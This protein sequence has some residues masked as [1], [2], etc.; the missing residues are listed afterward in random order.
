MRMASVATDSERRMVIRTRSTRPAPNYWPLPQ[1]QIPRH[2]LETS[3]V[4]EL[5]PRAWRWISLRLW[6]PTGLTLPGAIDW[7][8]V[9]N[10]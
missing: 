2:V 6:V 9:R 4:L 8:L 7:M 5:H 3:V 1:G 10:D